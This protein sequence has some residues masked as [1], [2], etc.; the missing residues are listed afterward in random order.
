MVQPNPQLDPPTGPEQG[1][2]GQDFSG[3]G[4]S[5]QDFSGQDFSAQN[6]EALDILVRAI[7][8]AQG[9]QEFSLILAQ[10]N[11][12][13]LRQVLLP[14][15][16]RR[17][18][19]YSP[20]VRLESLSLPSHLTNLYDAVEGAVADRAPK[21]LMI[22]GLEQVQ[23]IDR[24]LGA[25]NLMREEFRKGFGFPMVI[26]VNDVLLQK[27]TRQVPDIKSW[28]TSIEFFSSPE[29]LVNFL[30]RTT[31]Q[32]FAKV[33]RAGAG[34]F[35][36]RT[37]LFGQ[38]N[39]PQEIQAA[40][41]ELESQQ[42]ALAPDLEASVEF[43]LGQ[44]KAESLEVSRHHYERSLQGWTHSQNPQRQGCVLF[45]LG[46]W[47]RTFAAQNR[48][49]Y[50]MACGRARDYFQGA[51][52]Q[53]R[54]A[55]LLDLE[56]RFITAWGE[57]LQRL[58]QWDELETVA[59][60]G[61]EL[62]GPLDVEGLEQ[63]GSGREIAID[64]VDRALRWAY[65]YG[66]LATV[67]LERQQGSKALELA[68]RSLEILVELEGDDRYR[69]ILTEDESIRLTRD[70]HRS[71]YLFTLARAL[72]HQGDKELAL[73]KLEL[74][75]E[76]GAPQYD[77]PLY[78]EILNTLRDQYYV[79]RKDY[80]KAFEAKQERLSLEQ[81]YRFRAFVGAGRLQSQKEVVNPGLVRTETSQVSQEIAASGRQLD[82]QRLIG[83]MG[84]DDHKLT[85]IYGQSGVGKSSLLQAGFI[86]AVLPEVIDARRPVVVLQQVYT[87]W[88]GGLGEAVQRG[89]QRLAQGP[90]SEQWQAPDLPPLDTGSP[91][92]ILATFQTLS[93][94]NLLTIVVLD[95][96]EEFFFEYT[97]PIARKPFYDFLRDCLDIPHVKVILSLRE[98]YLHYLLECNRLEKLEVV[99]NDILSKHILSYL[100]NFSKDDTRSVIEAL[101]GRSHMALQSDLVEALVDDLA[102]P[103]GEVRPI[104][105]QVVG[106]QLQTEQIRLLSQYQDRGPKEALVGRF[107][108]EVVLDCGPEQEQVTKLVLYLLTD[109]N[110]TRPLKTRSD[111]ELELDVEPER[112][113]LI[114]T[115][116]VRARLVFLV[117]S[118]PEDRYQLVHDYLVEFVRREQS[119]RLIAEI[120]QEREKRR[121][122]EKRLQEVQRQ[123]L[124]ATRRAR[125]RLV[126]LVAAMGCFAII[127]SVVGVNFYL[128]SLRLSVDQKWGFERLISAMKVAKTQQRL[129]WLT[130]PEV[131]RNI[132]FELASAMHSAHDI[133]TLLEGHTGR[134]TDAKFS[135][136]DQLVVTASEDR[137]LKL[138]TIEGELLNT[139]EGHSDTVN[140]VTFRP[141]GKI[142]ASASKDETIRLWNLDG[143]ELQ[144]LEGHSGNINRLSFSSDGHLLAS[145]SDD[146]TVRV[147]QS[148]EGEQYKLIAVFL[149]HKDDVKSVNFS[150]DG[151]RLISSDLDGII[152]IWSVTGN[153]LQ[154]IEL[155][156]FPKFVQKKSSWTSASFTEDDQKIQAL[157]KTNSDYDS[158]QS[159]WIYSSNGDLNYT[160]NITRSDAGFGL[161]YNKL[162]QSKQINL[163]NRLLN[164]QAFELSKNRELYIARH[165]FSLNSFVVSKANSG[166]ANNI[167]MQSCSKQISS[168]LC[169]F[170][171]NQ[172]SNF[173]HR[174][175]WVQEEE[176]IPFDQVRQIHDFDGQRLLSSNA[177]VKFD[178]IDLNNIDSRF[179]ID[180]DSKIEQVYFTPDK[181]VIL[182]VTKGDSIIKLNKSKPSTVIDLISNY[183]RPVADISFNPDGSLFA[184]VDAEGNIGIYTIHGSPI[185]QIPSKNNAIP[186]LSFSPDSRFLTLSRSGYTPDI[187]NLETLQLQE[188]KDLNFDDYTGGQGRFSQNG[189]FFAFLNGTNAVKLWKDN[190]TLIDFISS[191][192]QVQDFLF[193]RDSSRLFTLSTSNTNSK[194]EIA[195][196]NLE[197][198]SLLD[199]LDLPYGNSYYWLRF[200]EN[201]QLLVVRGAGFTG[202]WDIDSDQIG[203]RPLIDSHKFNQFK[204]NQFRFTS[205]RGLMV[206]VEDRQNIKL[207]DLE[208]IEEEPG[209]LSSHQSDIKIIRF[210]SD[211]TKVISVSSNREQFDYTSQIDSDQHYTT[212]QQGVEDL[213]LEVVK[214]WDLDQNKEIFSKDA[215]R[216]IIGSDGES[217]ITIDYL[218]SGY[219]LS[220]WN[221]QGESI[222]DDLPIDKGAD[223]FFSLDAQTVVIVTQEDFY[224][225][226]FD[227]DGNEKR[228]ENHKSE[229][230]DAAFHPNGKLLASASNDG[231]LSVFDHQGPVIDL[232]Q[233]HDGLIK[234]VLFSPHG[235]MIAS[236][237]DDRMTK[238]WQ[239]DGTL[240]KSI[241]A[242]GEEIQKILFSPDNEKMVVSDDRSVRLWKIQ[243]D[244][245]I[246][247]HDQALSSIGFSPDSQILAGYNSASNE[248]KLWDSKGTILKNYSSGSSSK[249]NI[250]ND[251]KAIALGG[252]LRSVG[253][254]FSKDERWYFNGLNNLNFGPMNNSLIGF[255]GSGEFTRIPLD[256]DT[257][258]Q[259][260]CDLAQDF[261]RHNPSLTESDRKLC[262]P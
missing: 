81:Q 160:M 237:G 3:Q 67:V 52:H 227:F 233:G 174:S 198:N 23:G 124:Y 77:P 114:L 32:V 224:L 102:Q 97:N 139:L 254:I 162:H 31:D 259:Q 37:A 27:L 60:R 167:R 242:K 17:C 235:D 103:L 203:R 222:I 241:E 211:D 216:V 192:K 245:L 28:A 163:I 41:A 175:V 36:D 80:L 231:T 193:T 57:V 217:I 157:A 212:L 186:H 257:L 5:G 89:L 168:S 72:L 138:W 129:S 141:D 179:E 166:Q 252:D 208:E 130:L 181:D 225:E 218:E 112:L 207:L 47:W 71:L 22:L 42:I 95:Q 204:F 7:A 191:E 134:V 40:V 184:I 195:L 1:F 51:I 123:E 228:I 24:V 164:N 100:G 220:F 75:R 76:T 8:L 230:K 173:W 249:I 244:H 14:E 226:L 126:G 82:V 142:I 238:I 232:W 116:L 55:N 83:R 180:Y 61:L 190:K 206:F 243:N 199:T 200:L 109:E 128:T 159:F 170:Q 258:L 172:F 153:L 248:L 84:R 98:D 93:Q 219:E 38:S 68:E 73:Q 197:D 79:E 91:T 155:Q 2:S 221:S 214:I 262:D 16:Q 253:G 177:K 250:S 223:V 171:A 49:Q 260:S 152:N 33:S 210:T 236:V 122:T 151:K 158:K 87:N 20:A 48:D 29:I 202:I 132:S 121:L 43:V 140:F 137:T 256:L 133:G 92:A 78:I 74:A 239:L 201:R 205:D 107:L 169:G 53:F 35:L 62:H 85:V 188:F 13:D 187:L 69:T 127:S 113:D 149:D 45:H 54:S 178:L 6:H 147:W 118:S 59:L 104:E 10:C 106:A 135:P 18:G 30:H 110:N 96:F 194:S 196:W 176:L 44:I 39:L 165:E 12:G 120:E 125:N 136:D 50:D 143:E 117:P 25:M 88:Y 154:Q 246:D 251:N 148:E 185:H 213:P 108:E 145:A 63:E 234:Q 156:D 99:N 34:R 4:F 46:L 64:R 247:I 9:T 21:A 119:A 19:H 58:G 146:H 183:N 86:P 240:I 229:I 115:I 94:R 70:Y 144:I 26:W 209:S 56:G 131:K 111:L 182:A 11:Y 189:D 65:D 150:A 101:T 215:H 15:L 161:D 90:G 66:L 261:L 105:L 255:S